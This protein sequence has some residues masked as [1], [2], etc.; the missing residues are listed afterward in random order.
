MDPIRTPV[1]NT[2]PLSKALQ[3]SVIRG[4]DSLAALLVQG[5]RDAAA[6][7]RHASLTMRSAKVMR[8]VAAFMG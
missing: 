1:E 7:G 4:W 6:R 3:E 8:R 2:P 5:V